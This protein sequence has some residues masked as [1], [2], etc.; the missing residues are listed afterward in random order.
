MMT[1]NYL[2]VKLLSLVDQVPLPSQEKRKRRGRPYVYPTRLIIKL[3]IVMIFRRIRSAYALHQFLNQDLPEI[4]ELRKALFGNGPMPSRRTIERRLS[5]LAEA[6]HQ[7][8]VALGQML[9]SRLK[10]WDST[11][12][13][14]VAIDSVT[15]HAC[16][17]VWHKE[18]Q[19]KGIVPDTRIDTE[20]GWTKS[21][22]HGWVYG[23][24]LHVIVTASRI[25]I[26]L[27]AWATAANTA[28]NIIAYNL[29]GKLPKCIRWLL[30]DTSFQDEKLEKLCASQGIQ[31]VTP[32]RGGSYPRQDPG[33]PVRR[34]LHT[35]R[36]VT[37][38][39]FFAHFKDVFELVYQVPTRGKVRT[40]LF[41]LGCVYVYQLVLLLQLE[42][43]QQPMQGFKALLQAI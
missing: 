24:K 13:A 32:K 37:I 42:L 5:I 6:L 1:R 28:D 9:L 17:G 12:A 27:I 34:V 40:T 14:A 41:L 8:I 26:P 20:A 31:L 35:V 29:V 30:G 19:E 16:G 3:W 36:D 38:E 21:G 39:R 33:A 23:W 11:S 22:W 4:Q 10:W 2:L 25:L 43:G 7:E 18:H 15:F